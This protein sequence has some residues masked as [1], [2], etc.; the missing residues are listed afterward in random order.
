MHNLITVDRLILSCYIGATVVYV[1]VCDYDYDEGDR[2]RNVIVIV[3]SQGEVI[4]L[5]SNISD[6]IYGC[7]SPRIG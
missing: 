6:V 4:T 5:D 3:V 7:D 2:Y 1:V